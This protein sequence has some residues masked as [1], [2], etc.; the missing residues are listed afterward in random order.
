MLAYTLRRVLLAIPVMAVV[1]V[2]IFGM[3]YLTPGDPALV[4]AGDTATPAEVEHI[5][6]SLGL[7][8][9]MLLRL[10]QWLWRILQGNLGT[11]IFS[12]QSVTQMIAQRLAPTLSLLCLSVLIS[13][14][15]GVPFGVLAAW[16]PGGGWDRALGVYGVL[17]FSVPVF[18][19]GYALAY[20]FASWLRWL[21]VQG[22]VPI[23]A[24]LWPYLRTLILP[25]LTLSIV[26]SALIASVTR[27]AMLEVLGQDYIRTAIAKGAAR[28]TVLFGHALRNAGVP[29]VTVIGGGMA[30]LIGGAVITEGIFAIPGV[31]RLTLDAILHR[32]YPVIQAVVLLSSGCYVLINLLVDLIYTVIDPRIRY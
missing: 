13:V 10:G 28:R 23:G 4:I 15:V 26:Y 20:V 11:S 22:F 16:R 19:A 25:A 6:H 14:A 21:P 24:G 27:S 18:V 8:E 31:G 32:D 30:T 7:D 9:P 5:R 1:A 12:G 17:G 2:I 3:L 29:I